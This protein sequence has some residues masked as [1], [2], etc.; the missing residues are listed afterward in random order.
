VESVVVVILFALFAGMV[1]YLIQP[2]D[3]RD[4]RRPA[5][6]GAVT[7]SPAPPFVERR[8]AGDRFGLRR[9]KDFF[10]QRRR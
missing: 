10:L 1:A 4:P 6:L 5:A 8:R 3:R 7:D 9:L 2:R